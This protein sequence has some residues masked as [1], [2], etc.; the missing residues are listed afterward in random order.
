VLTLLGEDLS[1]RLRQRLL[2]GF[3][4]GAGDCGGDATDHE[5]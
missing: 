1:D 4:A 5:R 2:S 3:P